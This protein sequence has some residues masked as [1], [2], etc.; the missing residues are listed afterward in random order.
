MEPQGPFCQSCAMPMSKPED[1]GTNADGSKNEEYC[2]YC[3]KDGSFTN[4]DISMEEMIEISAKG[5]AESDPNMTY[6][7]AKAQL[8]QFFPMLKRWQ[9]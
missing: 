1:F 5:W 2:S 3:F 6:E 4:P 8:L 7:Q 9:K